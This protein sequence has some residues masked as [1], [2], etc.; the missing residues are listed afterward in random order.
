MTPADE[1]AYGSSG[2][3]SGSAR[4]RSRRPRRARVGWSPPAAA[5]LALVGTQCAGEGADPS[6]TEVPAAWAPLT[7]PHRVQGIVSGLEA[8]SDGTLHLDLHAAAWHEVV[9]VEVHDGQWSVDV[10]EPVRL[11]VL[12]LEL[13]GRVATLAGPDRTF[14]IHRGPIDLR[15]RIVEPTVLH[16]VDERTR[17]PLRDILVCRLEGWEADLEHPGE[18]ARDGVLVS[19]PD[20]PV[21]VVPT[22]EDALA[23]SVALYVHSPGYAWKQVSVSLAGGGKPTVS[24]AR[25]GDLSVAIEGAAP[26]RDAWLRLWREGASFPSA[27]FRVPPSG[28][29]TVDAVEPGTW[30]VT[31][32]LGSWYEDPIVV[33]EKEARVTAGEITQVRI[34][35]RSPP[36]TPGTG[37]VPLSGVVVLPTEWGLSRFI[38]TCRPRSE[39]GGGEQSFV[40]SDSMRRLDGSPDEWSWDL[41]QVAAGEYLLTVQELECS[42]P[43]TVGEDGRSDPRVEVPLPGNVLVTVIEE[44]TGAPASEVEELNWAGARP[45]WTGGGSYVTVLAGSAPGRFEFRAP[46][47]DIRIRLPDEPT[48][49]RLTVEESTTFE[50][51]LPPRPSGKR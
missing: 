17:A 27:E 3:A 11:E 46:R 19:S 18:H 41:G 21:R 42:F 22:P 10:P 34:T 26:P 38:L 2:S 14:S 16:V 45:S 5:L 47:G 28:D 13:N 9:S 48:S 23:P 4:A 49:W 32:E 50:I 15:A 30:R 31:L 33:G 1:V 39:R 29:V 37:L 43:V 20:S 51:R 12:G 25:A 36:E 8:P 24:M 35:A 7:Y 6:T 44:G 40:R